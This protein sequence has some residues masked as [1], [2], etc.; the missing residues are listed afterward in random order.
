MRTMVV[1]CCFGPVVQV[2][3]PGHKSD[4]GVTEQS[5]V[6]SLLGP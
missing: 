4:D 5:D 2:A 1:V 6:R 3:G